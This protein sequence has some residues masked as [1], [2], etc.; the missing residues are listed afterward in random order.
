VLE[1]LPPCRQRTEVGPELGAASFRGDDALL[2][3]EAK[4]GG[5]EPLQVRVARRSLV[6]GENGELLASDTVAVLRD[7]RED[8]ALAGAK[9]RA[10]RRLRFAV[11]D[12]GDLD[13]SGRL[14]LTS[15]AW[16]RPPGA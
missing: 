14:T 9:L 2:A 10:V 4:P 13:G 6:P 16:S 3:I 11:D 7:R 8:G 12:A 15:S 5:L 1:Q